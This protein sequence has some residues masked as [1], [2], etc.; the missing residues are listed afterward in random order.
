MPYDRKEEFKTTFE[1]KFAE[2]QITFEQ[3]D[4]KKIVTLDM[5]NVLIVF[6]QKH[7]P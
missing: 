3:K 1:H 6:A 4:Q 5:Y 2:A 7:M